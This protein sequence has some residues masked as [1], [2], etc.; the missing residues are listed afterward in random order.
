M[1]CPLCRTWRSKKSWSDGQWTASRAITN[2]IIG[3]KICRANPRPPLDV[4]SDKRNIV[5]RFAQ[6]LQKGR[7]CPCW[8]RL[9]WDW[10]HRLSADYRKT[11]SHLGAVR[12]F[13]ETHHPPH[14]TCPVLGD[15]F[16]PGN[17]VYATI[18]IL[19]VPTI[20]NVNWTKEKLGDIIEAML[21]TGM[22]PCSGKA[23]R[24]VAVWLEYASGLLYTICCWFPQ[25]CTTHDIMCL[26]NYAER[27]YPETPHP[28][29][30]DLLGM[31]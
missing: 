30:V 8:A 5:H 18:L 28:P 13:D 17:W 14:G 7:N 15:Y 23:A 3:C 31:D 16:D 27:F 9:I 25:V 21:A 6:E 26:M 19:L 12:C 20:V 10:M 29:A 22:R 1:E 24:A 4:L 2:G 11:A